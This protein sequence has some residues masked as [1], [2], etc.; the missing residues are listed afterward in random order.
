M[1]TLAQEYT[2]IALLPAQTIAATVTGSANDVEAY[3][4]DGMVIAS[5]PNTNTLNPA[6]VVTVTGSLVATPTVYDQTLATFTTTAASW[7]VAAKQVNLS[8]IK[9]VKGV[10]TLTGSTV[11]NVSVILLAR[12]G[13]KSA[14]ASSGTFA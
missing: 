14:N 5:I 2:P 11:T 12:D 4:E 13:V 1:R 10:A 3:I 8:G 6:V 9:N 7:G